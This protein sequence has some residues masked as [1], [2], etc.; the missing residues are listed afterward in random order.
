[1]LKTWYEATFL[2]KWCLKSGEKQGRNLEN[3]FHKSRYF[4][5]MSHGRFGSS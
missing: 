3:I 4:F 5:H 2:K 1:M